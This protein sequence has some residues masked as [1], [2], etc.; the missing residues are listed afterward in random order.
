MQVETYEAT[1]TT[2]DGAEC[3]QDAV[4]LMRELEL[5]GQLK[6]LEQSNGVANPYRK[7][8]AE[9]AF[10]YQRVCPKRTRLN[11]YDSG[12]VPLRVLQVAAHARTM[13][14]TLLVLHPEDVR[15]DPVLVGT[16]T[17]YNALHTRDDDHILARWGEVLLPLAELRAKAIADWRHEYDEKVA[18]LAAQLAGLQRVV[19]PEE[20]I[21]RG[22]SMPYASGHGL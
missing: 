15:I 10:V 9:E 20:A 19:V 8:T 13:F 18:A 7:M 22:A 12:W 5:D 3:T 6:R 2:V 17:K 1:E 14:T 4:Q 21:I 16:S 11:E